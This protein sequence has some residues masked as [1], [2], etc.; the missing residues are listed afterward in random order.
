MGYDGRDRFIH[1]AKTILVESVYSPKSRCASL[2]G[3]VFVNCTNRTIHTKRAATYAQPMGRGD[4]VEIEEFN[5]IVKV[6]ANSDTASNIH[7]NDVD[8]IFDFICR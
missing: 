6:G 1:F 7:V 5:R 4:A 3:L 2:V 8:E